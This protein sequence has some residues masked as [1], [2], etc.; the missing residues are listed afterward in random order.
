[1]T[2]PI[3]QAHKEELGTAYRVF[4]R[5]ESPA[6]R[7]EAARLIDFLQTERIAIPDSIGDP[8]EGLAC[9]RA[10][11]QAAHPDRKCIAFLLQG[12][13]E[14]VRAL[15]PASR[16]AFFQGLPELAPAMYDLH[17]AGMRQVVETVSAEPRT[18]RPIASYSMTTAEAIRAIVRIAHGA[19]SHQRL[20]L[21]EALVT[22]FPAQKMEEGK[23]AE[24]LL[25][26]I[27][28]TAQAAGSAWPQAMEVAVSLTRQNVSSAYGACSAL[29]GVLRKV[30]NTGA[31]LRDF[32][33]I[34][35]AVG[36]RSIGLCL[37]TLPGWHAKSAP[38]TV[39]RFVALGCEAAREFGAM[40]GMAFLE[41][42][43]TAARQLLP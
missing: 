12:F 41:R 39:H 27:A 9:L 10:A 1:M 36:L 5:L 8:P 34:A 38:E 30:A 14:W 43:T 11:V 29:P 16:D 42:K 24:R 13:P 33:A 37:N 22:A 31:Y 4:D 40:A 20:D 23:D 3:L 2:D 15:A 32:H 26:A 17:E 25:H 28:E 19:V 21:L 18:M 7:Q 35:E 6:L